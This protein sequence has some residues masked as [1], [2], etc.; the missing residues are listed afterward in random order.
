MKI[1]KLT[2]DVRCKRTPSKIREMIRVAMTDSNAV[3]RLG[4]KVTNNNNNKGVSNTRRSIVGH[5]V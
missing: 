4:G 2:K 1:L 5:V 3:V